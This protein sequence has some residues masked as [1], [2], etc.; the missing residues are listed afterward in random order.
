MGRMK[1]LTLSLMLSVLT[2]PTYASPAT[3]DDQLRYFAT[4]AGRLSAVMEYQWMFDGAASERTKIHRAAVIDLISAIMNPEQGRQVLH[5]RLVGKQAQST[6]LTRA[7]F[8]QNATDATWAREQATLY[9][10][11]CTS[12][13]LS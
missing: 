11:E 7:T 1:T 2:A 12:L 6:L 10:R 3:S 9:E 8:N 5:W 4:C 13:L